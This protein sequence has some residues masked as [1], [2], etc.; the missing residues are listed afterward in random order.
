[1]VSKCKILPPEPWD[2]NGKKTFEMFAKKLTAFMVLQELAWL[3]LLKWAE[4]Q[5]SPLTY[6]KMDALD[7]KGH[8]GE[9]RQRS[10]T[11]YYILGSLTEG[12]ANQ[13]VDTLPPGEGLEAWRRLTA[14]F[15]KTEDQC[16]LLGLVALANTKFTENDMLDQLQ[17]WE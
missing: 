13:L 2:P 1:M 16:A 10:V 7:A 15:T 4:G 14:T 3:N 11:L 5:T 8:E 9:A 6:A 17:T 12:S